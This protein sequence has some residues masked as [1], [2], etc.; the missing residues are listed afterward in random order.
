M[1]ERFVAVC[2]KVPDNTAYTALVALRKLGIHLSRVERAS[3]MKVSGDSDAEIIARVHRAE[4]VFNPNL[5]EAEVLASS[6][7]RLG[8]LWVRDDRSDNETTRWRLIG[9]DG[10]PAPKSVLERARDALLCNPAFQTAE[11]AG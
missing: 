2:L 7:P 11:L 5:H 3:I 10:K 1:M 9:E 6:I 4:S 8:E